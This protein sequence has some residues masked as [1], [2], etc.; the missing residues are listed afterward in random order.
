[1]NTS[2]IIKNKPNHIKR[3]RSYEEQLKSHQKPTRSCKKSEMKTTVGCTQRFQDNNEDQ[4][5]DHNDDHNYDHNDCLRPL[6]DA[7]H[8]DHGRAQ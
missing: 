5:H 2:K 1:M 4:N 8:E 7:V 3:P 6:H